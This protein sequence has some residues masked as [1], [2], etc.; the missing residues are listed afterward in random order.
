[1]SLNRHEK[2]SAQKVLLSEHQSTN[3]GSCSFNHAKKAKFEL[4]AS[5]E[6][7]PGQCFGEHEAEDTSNF[8][9]KATFDARAF[10]SGA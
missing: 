2:P 10:S 7:F 5:T 6:R 4:I 8:K 3:P 1:M 9:C